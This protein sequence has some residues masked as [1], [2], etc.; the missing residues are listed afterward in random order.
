[1][2]RIHRNTLTVTCRV[3][4]FDLEHISVA[5]YCSFMST[6]TVGFN[7]L[8]FML[9]KRPQ[10]FAAGTSLFP[11]NSFLERPFVLVLSSDDDVSNEE[12]DLR[13][14]PVPSSSDNP[15]Y[16]YWQMEY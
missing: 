7:T 14:P 12:R 2:P 8:F 6:S 3:L 10:R 4:I 11:G 15:I 9:F 16:L 5:V 13:T 1:M